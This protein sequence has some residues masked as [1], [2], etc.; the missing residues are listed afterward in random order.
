MSFDD[1]IRRN[2]RDELLGEATYRTLSRG[3]RNERMR[4]LLHE[5][6]EA[7][8][9]HAELWSQMAAARGVALK[10]LGF[11]DE[12]KVRSL[13]VLRRVVGLAVTVKILEAGEEE[14]ME[15]YY[16]LLRD[17]RFTEEERDVLK[18]IL[19]DEV[20]HEEL[21]TSEEFKVE[22]VRDAVYGVS[23]GL[24][25]VLAAVSGLAGF[26]SAP[27]LVALGGLIVGLSGTLSMSV[28]AYLSTK[29]ERETAEA[30]RRKAEM[31]S[32]LDRD[33][34]Q[35]RVKQQ[36]VDRGLDP[37][38]AARAS[39]ELRDVAEDVVAP[40]DPGDP[41][42]SAGV[43]AASYVVGAMVPVLAFLLGLGGLVGLVTSYVVTGMATMVVGSLIGVVSEVNP[44]RKGAEMSAMALGAALATHV[45]GLLAQTYLHVA[46]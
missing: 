46:I 18:R 12:L 5:I 17:Q 14:D 42:R 10:G 2:Y 21:L 31:Q 6:A 40:Q 9:G 38:K 19:E 8:A 26:I 20:V 23:D 44:L 28:G 33:A 43:T 11:L 13:S 45:V 34:L 41:L 39:R 25:E 32:V 7:E 4:R 1:E 22:N 35:E 27:Q 37:A 36:L 16:G 30:E 15:K 3:E 29:S 24:I